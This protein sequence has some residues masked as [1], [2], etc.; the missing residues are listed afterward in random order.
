MAA[1]RLFKRV[2]FLTTLIFSLLYI[3]S[4]FAEARPGGGHSSRSRSSEGGGS[5][6][7]GSSSSRGGGVRIGGIYFS[8]VE[9][10][11]LLIVVLAAWGIWWYLRSKKQ[12]QVETDTT[13]DSLDLLTRRRYA[14]ADLL[15][16]RANDPNFSEVLFLD[17][18]QLVFH[19]FYSLQGT[20]AIKE[21]SPYFYADFDDV[22]STVRY[23]ELVI[24]SMNIV[25]C[26]YHPEKGEEL[27]VAIEANCTQIDEKGKQKRYILSQEWSFFRFL[28]LTS[29]PPAKMQV[30]ACPSCGAADSFKDSKHCGACGT[31]INPSEHQWGVYHIATTYAASN[32]QK[33]EAAYEEET[34]TNLPTIFDAA[35]PQKLAQFAA[36]HQIQNIEN[37]INDFNQNLVRPSFMAI[38]SAWTAKTWHKTRHLVSD[39]LYETQNYWMQTYKEKGQTNHLENIQISK[40]D[41]VKLDMDKYY[42]SMTV[43]IFAACIDYTTDQTG[44]KIGGDTKKPRNFS[45][46]WTFV[47]RAGVETQKKDEW[48]IFAACP[49]CAA[50][51]D[52]IGMSG[53][54]GYCSNKISTG[55]FSW[56]LSRVTQD[57]AYI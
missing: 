54:C 4:N 49:A 22:T 27:V 21:L 30:L 48:A 20:S 6:E 47:R 10:L 33:T 26:N 56:V 43:R 55:E 35:L 34:G 39:F 25:E 41:F 57:E 31:E 19:K 18:A 46:Y 45:E 9:F 23:K 32:Q 11:L 7:G 28:G 24:N 44:K 38:Y 51:L 15:A 42:E 2:L 3:Y 16:L 1:Y 52:K 40:I 14:Q 13:D 37:Y 29:L 50:P 8:T 12:A 36:Q 5:S 53:E 17:F